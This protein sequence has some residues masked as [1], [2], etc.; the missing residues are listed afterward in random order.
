[1]TPTG[2]TSQPEA[3]PASVQIM[4]MSW[5]AIVVAR[6]VYAATKLGIPDLLQDRQLTSEELARATGAHP[7]AL[8]R[9]LSTLSSAD[10]LSE[11]EDHGFELTPLGNALRSEVEGS[12]RAFVLFA[13]EP[14]HLQT[15]QEILYSLQTG[16][17]SWDKVHGIPFF[18][19]IGQHPQIG[20]IFDEAMTDLSHG[21]AQ[22]VRLAGAVIR[23]L[24]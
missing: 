2:K 5:T 15:W 8:Y 17:P 12:I 3:L 7:Q 11:S 23:V 19:Y 14:C 16:K 18:E 4:N 24:A 1:M 13:C 9:L 10:V 20:T 6:A 21:E 22:T